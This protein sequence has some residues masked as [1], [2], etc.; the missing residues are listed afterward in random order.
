MNLERIPIHE[1]DP[2]LPQFHYDALQRKQM[3]SKGMTPEDI[4]AKENEITNLLAQLTFGPDL[5]EL[6]DSI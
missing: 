6:R 4:Q 2:S 3:E 1:Q 5:I